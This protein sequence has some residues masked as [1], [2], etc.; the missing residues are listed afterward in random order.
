MGGK[1]ACG[2]HCTK[3]NNISVK[4][5]KEQ[6]LK[7]VNIHVHCG[8]LT[9][10]IGRNGAGKSTLLKAILGEVEHTGNI[11]FVDMKDN[12]AK[13]IKNRICATNYKYRKTYAN[14][15]VRPICIMY[16]PHTSIFEKG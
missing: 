13:R 15:S 5:G 9:V 12:I 2:L 14:N 7:N 16:L 1:G 11:S 10:I 4:F 6:V 8:E 3:I